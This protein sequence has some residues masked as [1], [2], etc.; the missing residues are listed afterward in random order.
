MALDIDSKLFGEDHPNI[1]VEY[2]NI[3]IAYDYMGEYDKAIDFCQKAL[4]IFLK[5]LPEIHPTALTIK[6]NIEVAKEK[7]K[8]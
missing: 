4:N 5:F 8:K 6:E 1:A 7:Q 2:N 3:G